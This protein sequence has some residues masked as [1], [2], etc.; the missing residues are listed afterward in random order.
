MEDEMITIVN[1]LIL[2][3]NKNK[4]I[5][6]KLNIDLHKDLIEAEMYHRKTGEK[7]VL[8]YNGTDWENN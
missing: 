8:H 6:I 4:C 2:F 7:Y 1:D 3:A 5:L